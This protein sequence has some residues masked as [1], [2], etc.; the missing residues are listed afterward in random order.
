MKITFPHFT[1]AERIRFGGDPHYSHEKIQHS[2][3]VSGNGVNFPNFWPVIS[4]IFSQLLKHSPCPKCTAPPT[5][6]LSFATAEGDPSGPSQVVAEAQSATYT[7][8]AQISQHLSLDLN[9]F[10]EVATD[11]F[12]LAPQLVAFTRWMLHERAK[13]KFLH[14]DHKSLYTTS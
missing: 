13:I 6:D 8:P 3:S 1:S 2:F 11:Q 12:H 7:L 14:S 5:I 9:D 4:F 10:V